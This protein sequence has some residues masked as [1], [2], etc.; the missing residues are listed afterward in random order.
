MTNIL[1]SHITNNNNALAAK[2]ISGNEP[3]I[4]RVSG[5]VAAPDYFPKF[6][7]DSA[8]KEKQNFRQ[9][10]L[11]SNYIQKTKSKKTKNFILKAGLIISAA[12]AFFYVKG[13]K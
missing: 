5:P 7:I 1:N 3:S 9:D 12:A 4:K 11:Q 2:S 6:S 13:K 10:V 8:I